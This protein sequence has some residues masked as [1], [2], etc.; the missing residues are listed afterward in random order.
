MKAHKGGRDSSWDFLGE[1]EPY[2]RLRLAVVYV[3][4]MEYK[5]ALACENADEIKA[6]ERFFLSA[7][8]QLLS[9]NMGE[10][11]VEQVRKGYG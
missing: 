4:A 11:I 6:L 9:G 3:A 2:D 1:L 8:G 10:Y 5:H 7:W